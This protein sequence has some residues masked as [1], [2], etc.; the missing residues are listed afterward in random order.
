MPSLCVYELRNTC[1]I[2]MYCIHR[3]YFICSQLYAFLQNWVKFMCPVSCAQSIMYQLSDLFVL[4]LDFR[5]NLLWPS[6]HQLSLLLCYRSCTWYVIFVIQTLPVKGLVV[7]GWQTVHIIYW[8]CRH[9]VP[10][11]VGVSVAF[12]LAWWMSSVSM[13]KLVSLGLSLPK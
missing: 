9:S 4:S 1:V 8:C 3:Y 10:Y 7:A 12:H 11:L 6:I 5:F 13:M 2:S